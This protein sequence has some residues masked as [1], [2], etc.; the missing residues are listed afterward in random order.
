MPRVLLPVLLA[1]LLLAGCGSTKELAP[2]TVEERFAKARELYDDGSI[3]DALNEFTVITLQFQGSALADDAQYYLGECRFAREEYLLAVFEYQQLIRNTPAS[4]LVADAQYR[5]GTCFF[6][7]S[8]KSALDQQYTGKA[9]DELQSFVEYHPTHAEVPKAEE[10]IRELTTRLAGK[11]YEIGLQYDKLD[12][13]KAAIFYFNDVIEKYHDTE[14]APLAYLRKTELLFA[15]ERYAEAQAVIREFLERYPNSVFRGQADR[16]KERIERA[17]PPSSLNGMN[18][19]SPASA[20][21]EG[22]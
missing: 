14:F 22:G 19:T 1:A 4:P 5:I 11:A 3:Q 8:P 12:Y 18:G 9:I 7:L 6:R 20:H 2:P 13:T 21:A 17:L 16:L 15:R 10:M